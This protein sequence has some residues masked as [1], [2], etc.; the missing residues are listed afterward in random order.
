MALASLFLFHWESD[1]DAPDFRRAGRD[2][3]GQVGKA[4]RGQ[5]PEAPGRAGWEGPGAPEKDVISGGV[6]WS[7][8]ALTAVRGRWGKQR[9]FWSE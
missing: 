6:R 9:I 3:W 4:P 2:R 1:L 8:A 5:H 7:V